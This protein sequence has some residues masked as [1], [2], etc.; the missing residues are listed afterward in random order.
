[1]KPTPTTGPAGRRA[2]LG[3][4]A[5]VGVSAVLGVAAF[6]A[7]EPGSSHPAGAVVRAVE[8]T[9][10]PELSF[11]LP[12]QASR[13]T[14]V[15]GGAAVYR[16]RISRH[17]SLIR[18]H[19]HSRTAARIWLSVT[20]ALPSGVVVAFD[21]RST[22]ATRTTL[23]VRTRAGS[24]P[25]THRIRL[26][27][28]GRLRPGPRTP[29]REARTTVTLVVVSRGDV[30]NAPLPPAPVASQPPVVAPPVVS[31]PAGPPETHAFTIDGS[32]AVPLAPGVHAPLDL[33]LTNSELF[34]IKV[35]DLAVRVSAVHAPQA[36][37]AHPCAIGDFAVRDFSGAYGFA[38]PAS[39]TTSLSALGFTAAEL[40][41]VAMLERPL[42]QDGCKLATLTLTFDG[43]ATEA[44]R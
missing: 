29:M 10:R 28:R 35:I 31:P 9:R 44:P 36:D 27:A 26:T 41:D 38:L 17:G 40:P 13:R 32:V 22:R 43:V 12:R 4:A 18:R 19:G 1:M 23:T 42:D 8:P 5:A 30:A 7:T 37:A 25:G 20:A 16:L 3:A 24:R 39:G 14:V 34:A 6:A 11:D 15:A 21:P 33:I 2:L